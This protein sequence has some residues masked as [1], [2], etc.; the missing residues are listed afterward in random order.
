LLDDN[1]EPKYPILEK[2]NLWM[3]TLKII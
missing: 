2:P 1:F 3:P